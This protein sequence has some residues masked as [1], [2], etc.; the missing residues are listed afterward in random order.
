M[1]TADASACGRR[2]AD[3]SES[4][5]WLRTL[6]T[7]KLRT[8]TDADPRIPRIDHDLDD[9]K[10]IN[11]NDDDPAQQDD[12]DRYL[13]L[14]LSDEQTNSFNSVID[15]V[16]VFNITKFWFDPNI[17]AQFPLLCRVANWRLVS[18]A[19]LLVALAVSEFS[20]QPAARVLE[21]RRSQLSSSSV[22]ALLFMHSQHHAHSA[23]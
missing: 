9:W 4:A 12:V 11:D 16:P 13:A 10:D 1:R 22:D 17:Q 15:G 7:E 19:F 6:C 3:F 2:S 21:K 18:W 8:R 20:V 14:K 23:T 5:D